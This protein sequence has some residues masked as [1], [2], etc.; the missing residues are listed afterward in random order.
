LK[1]RWITWRSSV[2]DT[3]HIFHILDSIADY[4]RPAAARHFSEYGF[5]ETFQGQVDTL[6]W[7]IRNRITWMDANMPGNCWNLGV[8]DSPLQ[9]ELFTVFPNP[10]SNELTISFN[11]ATSEKISVEIFDPYGKK[12]Q[13]VPPKNYGAG[14]NKISFALPGLAAGVYFVHILTENG[15]V[16]KRIVKL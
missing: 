7:W 12:V 14:E 11:F 5:T 8:T 3:T 6:K 9:D 10:A 13:D 16:T 1:C 2:L 15:A 4:I